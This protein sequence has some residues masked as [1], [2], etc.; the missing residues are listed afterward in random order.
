MDTYLDDKM[1]D[2][3]E[4]PHVNPRWHNRAFS[5]FVRQDILRD[6]GRIVS[7]TELRNDISVRRVEFK[8]LIT[9]N[10]SKPLSKR[11][12]LDFTSAHQ[13]PL[14]SNPKLHYLNNQRQESV[15]SNNYESG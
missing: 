12:N 13:L 4:T 3:V 15:M 11:Y 2:R 7:K 14:H 8:K 5:S 6:F 9:S 1:E 10:L